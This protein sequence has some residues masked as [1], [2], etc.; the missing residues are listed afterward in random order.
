MTERVKR[1]GTSLHNVL[2]QF[3]ADVEWATTIIAHNLDF[4]L[5]IVDTGFT[6]FRPQENSA[7]SLP[8]I[9]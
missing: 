6:R 3:N 5:Q 2:L 9:F 7:C 1:E 4:D 8:E